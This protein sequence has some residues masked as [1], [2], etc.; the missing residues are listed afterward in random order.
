MIVIDTSVA[1]KWAQRDEEYSTQAI[2]LQ[3]RHLEKNV[4][5][6]APQ[7]INYEY[8]NALT[9]MSALN[10]IQIEKSI[11]ILFKTQV[12]TYHE[13]EEELLLTSKLAKKYKT[14]V[15]D[16]LYAVIAQSLDCPLVTADQKF[17]NKTGFKHVLHLSQI[18]I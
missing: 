8:A 7:L 2:Y 13:S 16:M 6:I 1:L 10:S 12:R 11:N 9:T 3:K 18:G 5:L 14:T 17:I 15:Y 4:T